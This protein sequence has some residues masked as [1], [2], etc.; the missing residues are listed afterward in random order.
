MNRSPRHRRAAL[1][2][3]ALFS[4]LVACTVEL[5]ETVHGSGTSSTEYRDVDGYRSVA[6]RGSIDARVR[7]GEPA[8]VMI[9][10]DDNL[11]E[12]VETSVEN[13][14][15]IVQ[16]RR[17]FRLD[18]APRIEIGASQLES[19]QLVGA[20]TLRVEGVDDET[21]E[22]GLEGSGDLECRG[23]VGQLVA[24]VTGSG[25]MDLFDLVAQDAQV[26]I[27]GS[28]DIETR[29]ERAL[30]VSVSG[31]GDVLYRGE[32]EISQSIAGSGEV[33]CAGKR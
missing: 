11:I 5:S 30:S 26:E 2:W 14:R 10:G 13:G 9:T 33:R 21:I 29:A 4:V 8:H 25:T 28:G 7:V 27:S 17:G 22:L 31:S 19:L 16:V 24:T 23:R 1:A 3:V 20:G 6:V 15:L 12:Y 18:P 32:P